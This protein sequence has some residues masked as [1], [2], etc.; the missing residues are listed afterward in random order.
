MKTVY[1]KKHK[2]RCRLE[3]ML[4]IA[5][6]T[7]ERPEPTQETARAQTQTVFLAGHTHYLTLWS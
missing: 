1:S 3:S 2:I 4:G 6:S 5:S 7:A